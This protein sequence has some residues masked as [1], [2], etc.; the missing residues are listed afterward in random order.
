MTKKRFSS[1]RFGPRYGTTSRKTV[2]EIEAVQKRPH[3]C[4][5]CNYTKVKR[6]FIG[7]WAC[8][9]C[10]LRFAGG[11]W[12]PKGTQVP[13]FSTAKERMLEEEAEF[14]KVFQDKQTSDAAEEK[15]KSK[16]EE[17]VER[18]VAVIVNDEK[19]KEEGAEEEKAAED[20][21]LRQETEPDQGE[22]V[23]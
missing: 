17:H 9:K 22:D 6:E 3:E 2:A 14:E 20:E 11:A 13:V 1:A 4:P 19:D 8:K 15:R 5:N 21:E 7:V 16:R 18:N 10:G 23:R 12:D